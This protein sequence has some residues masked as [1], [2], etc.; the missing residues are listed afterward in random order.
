[1]TTFLGSQPAPTPSTSRLE[2]DEEDVKRHCLGLLGD[3]VKSA[4]KMLEGAK[5]RDGWGRHEEAS[6]H[7]RLAATLLRIHAQ[8]AAAKQETMPSASKGPRYQR[9]VP[10]LHLVV[11]YARMRAKASRGGAAS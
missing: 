2:Q 1:M 11:H 3:P 7:R 4:Q 5:N 8:A 6:L 9:V 10:A